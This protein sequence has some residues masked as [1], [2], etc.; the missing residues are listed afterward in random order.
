MTRAVDENSDGSVE[1]NGQYY[2]KIFKGAI[3]KPTYKDLNQDGISDVRLTG[4][5]QI[6]LDEE[7]IYKQYPGQKVFIYSKEKKKFVEDLK[8]RKGFKK[9]DD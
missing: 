8:Q 6:C 5:I 1:I 7:H 2:D 4:T 3:L 9:D